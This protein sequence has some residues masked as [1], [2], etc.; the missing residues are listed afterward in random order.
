MDR[1]RLAH[2][3]QPDGD[4][5]ADASE[6]EPNDGGRLLAEGEDPF[7]EESA[8]EHPGQAYRCGPNKHGDE[9]PAAA[10]TIGA[11]PSGDTIGNYCLR[12]SNGATAAYLPEWS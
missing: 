5:T 10:E 7:G 8:E 9:R 2:D 1:C 12:Y 3:R 4:H 6:G 11:I